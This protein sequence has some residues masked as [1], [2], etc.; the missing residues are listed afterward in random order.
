MKKIDYKL[1]D[2]THE[3]YNI[4]QVYIDGIPSYKECFYKSDDPYSKF[5][6]S[7]SDAYEKHIFINEMLDSGKDL[8]DLAIMFGVNTVTIRYYRDKVY[9]HC[10][11]NKYRKMSNTER[12]KFEN[13]L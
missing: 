2:D 8:S 4:Y 12:R 11:V 3:K 13:V 6:W 1:I 10:S 5:N 9:E 7:Q